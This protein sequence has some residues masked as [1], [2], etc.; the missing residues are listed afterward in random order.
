MKENIIIDNIKSI[1]TNCQFRELNELEVE[2]IENL[3]SRF[4]SLSNYS[5]VVL[6]D[7]VEVTKN[8]NA[9]FL[10]LLSITYS[11]KGIKSP[12]NENRFSEYE[13]IG[14][15][16]LRRDYG[17]VLIR[18]ETFSD[19]INDLFLS[20]DID[21]DYDKDFSKKYFVVSNDESKIRN[22][23]SRSFLETV[24]KYNGLEIELDSNI[25]LVRLRKPF[26]P[27]NGKIITNFITAIN[28]SYN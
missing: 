2:N 18:P 28:D 13:L 12:Q 23:I 14:I 10:L 7:V 4:D 22:N 25:L 19:K 27:E 11:H 26:T 21:F 1:M 3:I 9:S 8:Q 17:R 24:R 6:S 20:I 16:I 15:A 5:L